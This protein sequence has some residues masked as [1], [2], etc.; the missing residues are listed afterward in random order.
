MYGKKIIRVIVIALSYYCALL[1]SVDCFAEDQALAQLEMLQNSYLNKSK[2]FTS[3]KKRTVDLSQRH[4]EKDAKGKAQ[5]ATKKSSK[6]TLDYTDEELIDEKAFNEV[7]KRLF[8]LSHEQVLRL[9]QRYN[10]SEFSLAATPGTPPRAASTSQMVNL[11]PGA[12]PPVIR[13]AQ[14]FVTSVVFLDS[15]GAPW[16]IVA[17]DLGD[18]SAFNVVWDKSGNTLMMQSNKMYTYG[19]MAVKLQG[20]NT[21]VML[22]IVP[23]QK[24][25]DYRIDMRVQGYGPN[26]KLLPTGVGLPPS[27]DD[28]LLKVLD[29][30]PPKGA[31]KLSV[32]GGPGK[33]W[34]QGDRMFVR[35]R[36]TILSPGWIST[37]TSADGTHA[38]LMP[39]APVLL[40]SW[41]GK[42]MQ[43]KL[44]GL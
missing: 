8:P 24:A 40:V 6:D 41:H 14:R 38:Y 21:P 31:T 18:P 35:T 16:P 25:V 26:A 22:T 23:G 12:T 7:Q 36:L 9:H 5:H 27:A 32:R 17:Y 37:M 34:L 20:L 19:N 33:A 3:Q 42:V 39:P 13:L 29:G 44:E 30:V 11:S 15:T 10:A 43:I 28:E 4:S 1:V 2:P